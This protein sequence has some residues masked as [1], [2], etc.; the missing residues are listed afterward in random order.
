M[1]QVRIALPSDASAIG[2]VIRSESSDFLVDPE[3]DEA[4]RFFAALE[5]E[6]IEKAIAD[7]SRFYMVAV[8][9]GVVVGVINVR[10]QNYVSQFFVAN[11]HQR[12][13]V[14]RLLWEHALKRVVLAGGTGEFTVSSSLAAQAIYARFGFLPTGE[15]TIQNGFRFVPMRRAAAK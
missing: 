7:P 4:R 15:Q 12:R 8:D 3:G 6:G 2:A 11:T 10:D 1:V 13:G 5:P 9:R 14:G